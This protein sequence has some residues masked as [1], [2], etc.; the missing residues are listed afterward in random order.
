MWCEIW[1]S[2]EMYGRLK[3]SSNASTNDELISHSNVE[4]LENRLWRYNV[5]DIAQGLV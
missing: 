2:R 3:N 5:I 1:N 4:S